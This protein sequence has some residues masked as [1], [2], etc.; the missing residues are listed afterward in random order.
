MEQQRLLSKEVPKTEHLD[1]LCHGQHFN[2]P[3]EE[4]QHHVALIR[5]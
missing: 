1:K 2:D 3:S 4:P 5:G